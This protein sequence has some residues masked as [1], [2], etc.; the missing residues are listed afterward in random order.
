MEPVVDENS[1]PLAKKIKKE[2]SN[3][4]QIIKKNKQSPTKLFDKSKEETKAILTRRRSTR[5][6]V[7]N[8]NLKNEL[9][10]DKEKPKTTNNFIIEKDEKMHLIPRNYWIEFFDEEEQRWICKLI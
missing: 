9:K 8:N 2:T 6:S 3:T 10:V 5:Q 7:L 4:N 1:Q